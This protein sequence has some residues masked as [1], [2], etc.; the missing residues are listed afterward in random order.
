I[1]FGHAGQLWI[2]GRDGGQ[3][4]R[5]VTGQQRNFHPVFSPDGTQIAFTGVFDGNPD[6]YVVP[7]AGGEPRR[8]TF[9]TGFD[10]AIGW[11][12]D[13]TRVLFASERT[14]QRDLPQLF[15]VPLTGGLPEA[16]PLPS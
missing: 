8:L 16:I 1:A 4:R 9:H 14:T 10:A 3:A 2:V 6:V 13:G 11:T 7:A 5:L 15:T 12:P